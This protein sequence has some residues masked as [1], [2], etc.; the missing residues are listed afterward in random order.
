MPSLSLQIAADTSGDPAI[1]ISQGAFKLVCPRTIRQVKPEEFNRIT[2]LMMWFPCSILGNEDLFREIFEFMAQTGGAWSQMCQELRIMSQSGIFFAFSSTLVT[3]NPKKGWFSAFSHY[4]GTDCMKVMGSWIG[5][6]SETNYSMARNWPFISNG[7]K[8][9]FGRKHSGLWESCLQIQAAT[10]ILLIELILQTHNGT[11]SDILL[12]NIHFNQERHGNKRQ[13]IV[14]Y[15]DN[16][17]DYVLSIVF[18]GREGTFCNQ[19]T[20]VLNSSK[21]NPPHGVQTLV[22]VEAAEAD[23][24]Y[25]VDEVM[26]GWIC[27][28]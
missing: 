13:Q 26:H 7:Y 15:T 3:C 25:E 21:I 2:W 22:L 24:A 1:I 4:F 6:Q 17:D 8:V 20:S 14:Y 5:S 16:I 18:G 12:Q 28:D 27:K 11:D 9:R 23:K 19:R 10:R